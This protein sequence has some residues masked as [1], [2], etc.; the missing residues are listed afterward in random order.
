MTGDLAG[1]IFSWHLSETSMKNQYMTAED[2]GFHDCKHN[3]QQKIHE[4]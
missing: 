4:S 1:Q 2:N 3:R